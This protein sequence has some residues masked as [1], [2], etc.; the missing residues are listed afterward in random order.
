MK[1]NHNKID[2]NNVDDVVSLTPMQRGMLYHYVTDPDSEMYVEQLCVELN[3]SIDAEIFK[4]AWDTVTCHNEVLRSVFRWEKIQHPVQIILNKKSVPIQWIDLSQSTDHSKLVEQYKQNDKTKYIDIGEHPVRITLIQLNES[5]H[6]MLLT[7]HH[8]LFDGWSNGIILKEFS[9]IYDSFKQ[10]QPLVLPEKPTYSSYISRLKQF[11]HTNEMDYWKEVLHSYEH[12][13]TIP[14]D[15][16]NE[17]VMH[18]K[19]LDCM[20]D[21]Q[22]KQE[23]ENSV[24]T[25]QITLA[26]FMYTAWGICLQK[27][28]NTKDVVFGTTVSGRNLDFKGIE[29]MV[30]LFINT[31]PLRLKSE[32]NETV[33]SLLKRTHQLL[34]DRQA[35]ETSPLYDIEATV[36]KP[37]ELTSLFDS[38]VI[39]ENY[40]LDQQNF[41]RGDLNISGFMMEEATNY[42]L[43]LVI[44]TFDQLMFTL[45]YNA[46][47]I[48]RELIEPLAQHFIN[49]LR[50]M[51][52]HPGQH[53][54]SFN[55]LTDEETYRISGSF[56]QT[57]HIYPED[58][59][60]IQMFE[61]QVMRNPDKSALCFEGLELSYAALNEKANQLAWHLIQKGIQPNKLVGVMVERSIE[62]IVGVLGILKAGAA[63]LPIDPDYPEERITYLLDH[64]NTDLLVTERKFGHLI[65]EHQSKIIELDGLLKN[66]TYPSHNPDVVYDPD[67]LLYVLYTSGSTGRPKGVMVRSKAFVNLIDWFN[68]EFGINEQDRNLL[69]AP[70]SFDLA[71]KNLFSSLISGGTLHL[72]TPGIY[73]YRSMSDVIDKE[74]ITLLNC[75]PSAFYPLVDFNEG[76]DFEKLKSLRIVFL[77][78][79]PIHFSKLSAW[80][81]SKHYHCEIAN[82]YGPTECTDISSFYRIKDRP[83]SSDRNAPIGKPISNAKLYILDQ[84]LNILPIGVPGELYIGGSG[85]AKGYYRDPDL[86]KEKFVSC[87]H[88][89][90]KR[91]YRTGDLAKWLSDGNIQYLGRIDDQVKI[92]G[93]RIETQEIEVKLL[94]FE[95]IQEV[96]VMERVRENGQTYLCAYVVA[97]RGLDSHE[98][99]QYLSKKLPAFMVPS[100]FIQIEAFPLTPN[101][102]LNRKNLPTPSDNERTKHVRVYSMSNTEKEIFNI[103]HKVLGQEPASIYDRFLEVGGNSI[104]M[105][106]MHALIERQYPDVVSISDLFSYPTISEL[107]DFISASNDQEESQSDFHFRGVTINGF[108]RG[109]AS[110]RN[111]YMESVEIGS[112]PTQYIEALVKSEQIELQDILVSIF[113]YTLA[114][115]MA[116]DQVGIQVVQNETMVSLEVGFNQLNNF[117]ELFQLVHRSIEENNTGFAGFNLIDTLNLERASSDKHCASILIYSKQNMKV[118]YTDLFDLLFV[119]EKKQDQL[120]FMIFANEMKINRGKVKDILMGCVQVIDMMMNQYPLHGKE[121]T[122]K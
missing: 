113:S 4:Q 95:S 61:A 62:M 40:P 110:K 16:A 93:Y 9:H 91:I 88:L 85:L 68:R 97:D 82:T 81:Q 106:Q 38:I 96:L 17:R 31:I 20:I 107:A 72:F 112:H 63:Y 12:K 55:L 65:Q 67:Q 33:Q 53:L 71:Q 101:G 98:L 69:I 73:D 59:S 1:V 41:T 99:R 74:C 5:K 94:Q 3:G 46:N 35:Y 121:V 8:I 104:S 116:V 78:G 21:E 7:S 84:D 86:T 48:S 11:D 14:K 60:L 109:F 120:E 51:T 47:V 77:G 92:N 44:K 117:M 70:F 28:G 52:K 57:E 29:H 103:W 75:A 50:Y 54:S 19:Y 18:T 76:H 80:S 118:K 26:T 45:A 43:N 122:E 42:D 58:M 49:T 37:S 114:E 111:M 64:S 90:T 15:Q 115:L 30:G 119:F 13:V 24:K 2:K 56:N 10:H 22:L 102:K 89:P 39:L 66:E 108:Y 34:I 32:Q 105:L 6:V 79:E 36:Q 83:I 25:H 23:I 87:S 100:Y 27:Y